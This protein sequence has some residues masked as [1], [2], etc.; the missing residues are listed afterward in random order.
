MGN[1]QNMKIKLIVSFSILFLILLASCNSQYIFTQPTNFATNTAVLNSAI[2]TMTIISTITPSP[3]FSHAQETSSVYNTRVAIV[4]NTQEYVLNTAIPSTLEAKNVK[5]K[6]GFFIVYPLETLIYSSEDWTLFTCSTIKEN[7]NNMWTP[8]LVHGKRYTQITKSDSSQ[9]WIIYDNSLDPIINSV[10]AFMI[11]YRWTE[12]GKY[13]YL[14]PYYSSSGS[15]YPQSNFLYT[16]IS[17][18]YRI[19]LDT[20]YFELILQSDQYGALELSPD[21]HFL[22]YSEKINPDIIHIRNM[23]TGNDQQIKLNENIVAAGAFIWNSESTK[24]V[25]FV[26]YENKGGN[27]QNDLSSTSIFVLT[28]HNMHLQT[29]LAKDTRKFALDEC[30]NKEYWIDKNTICIYS[31]DRELSYWENKFTFNIRTGILEPIPHP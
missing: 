20:G 14:R 26:G 9:T 30:P 12:D 5:C 16:Y 27:W 6:E 4:N 7:N 3:T 2:P 31:V 22:A 8:D 21:G 13:L 17:D 11:P 10:G 25:F 1:Q 23:E 24:V 18:L 19:N 15:G 29:V 28:P